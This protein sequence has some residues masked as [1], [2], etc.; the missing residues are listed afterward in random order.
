MQNVVKVVFG[1]LEQEGGAAQ[2]RFPNHPL[3]FS[4][5]RIFFK[6]YSSS[7]CSRGAFVSRAFVLVRGCEFKTA[8][9]SRENLPSCCEFLEEGE[10]YYCIE[11]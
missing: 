9:H 11:L 2:R 7:R 10:R 6:G 3:I 1:R 4:F 8:V 5:C